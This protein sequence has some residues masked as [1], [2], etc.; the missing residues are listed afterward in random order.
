M[1]WEEMEDIVIIYPEFLSIWIPLQSIQQ[2][3]IQFTYVFNVIGDET[4]IRRVKTDVNQIHISVSCS[5]VIK[6]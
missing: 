1:K 2:L 5:M 4:D 3:L 6:L